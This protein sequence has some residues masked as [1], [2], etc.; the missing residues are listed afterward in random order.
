MNSSTTTAGALIL[1]LVAVAGAGVS[2][3]FTL[4]AR[5][6]AIE[7]KLDQNAVA[8]QQYQIAQDTAASSKSDALTNLDKEVDALQ[9]SLGQA[10]HAQTDTL[11]DL[12]KQITTLQQSQQAQENAQKKL[13]DYASQMDRIKHDVEIMPAQ[14]SPAPVVTA[15]VITTV[16]A[17]A[18]I[19]VTA[20]AA[21][22][23]ITTADIKTDATPN[24]QLPV[25]PRADG[26]SVDLRP[27]SIAAAAPTTTRAFPIALPVSLSQ[28]T[29]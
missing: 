18:P 10:S 8:F 23:P 11:D 20:P 14:V 6:T 22:A 26:A 7:Q 16:P 17:P 9:A 25:P 2:Y 15:P 27:A 13:S 24:V 28:A 19:H 29:P 5:F 1:I 12:R 3:H 4:E 21:P